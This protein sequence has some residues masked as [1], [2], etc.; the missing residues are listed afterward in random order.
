MKNLNFT[1][2]PKPSYRG[3]KYS[4][5]IK[6]EKNLDIEK[7]DSYFTNKNT[8]NVCFPIDKKINIEGVHFYNLFFGQILVI[9]ISNSEGA[10]IRDKEKNEIVTLEIK[11]ENLE[12]ISNNFDL[13]SCEKLHVFIYNDKGSYPGLYA[14]ENKES[15]F[16]PDETEGGGVI[17]T[18]P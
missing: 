1:N 10:R 14:K 3:I 16:N 7:F 2:P 17:I 11:E 13:S 8:L 6:Y 15:R 12:T 18:G 5:Q 4:E 9:H